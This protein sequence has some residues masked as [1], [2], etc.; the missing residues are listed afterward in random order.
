[1]LDPLT[2]EGLHGPQMF[3]LVL[4]NFSWSQRAPGFEL[5][6]GPVLADGGR[7]HEL[8]SAKAYDAL[9][10]DSQGKI[11]A[12]WHDVTD[13]TQTAAIRDKARELLTQ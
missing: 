11:A 12:S 3:A 5:L 2:R 7:V 1:M 10:I 8:Y 4:D 6:E 9:L 13:M